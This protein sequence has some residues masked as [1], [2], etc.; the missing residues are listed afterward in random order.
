M[1]ILG[2]IVYER[3]VA[4]SKPK[5]IHRMVTHKLVLLAASACFIPVFLIAVGLFFPVRP[6]RRFKEYFVATGM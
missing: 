5:H 4:V 3:H 2:I 6:V 1:T